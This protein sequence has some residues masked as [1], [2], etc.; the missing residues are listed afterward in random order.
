M[1]GAEPEMDR[2]TAADISRRLREI[3]E[4][5]AE[6]GGSHSLDEEQARLLDYTK[7]FAS[8][9]KL[10]SQLKRDHENIAKQLRNF[11]H[12]LDRDMPRLAAHLK[13]SLKLSFPH[14]GYYP[15][16]PAPDWQF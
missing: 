2:Q 6:T 15:P 8:E 5:R 4:I 12:R 11:R 16:D 9:K 10:G 14:F 7:Q 3:E 13:V 1:L